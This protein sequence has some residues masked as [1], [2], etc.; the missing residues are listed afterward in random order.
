MPRTHASLKGDLYDVIINATS[1]GHK[2]AVPRLPGQL[3]APGG[4]CY[5][6]SYN[7]AHEAFAA[8]ARDQGARVNADGLGMLVEQAAVGFELWRGVRPET[9]SVLKE[10]RAG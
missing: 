7:K 5:D 8:W 1:A 2:G 6:L 10:L 9:A 3:L 4:D